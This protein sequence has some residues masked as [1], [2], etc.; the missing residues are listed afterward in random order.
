MK[1]AVLVLAALAGFGAAVPSAAQEAM[2]TVAVTGFRAS[3][4]TTIPFVVLTRRADHLYTS[5]TVED[6]TRDA[7]IRTEELRNTLKAVLAA[8][9]SD[10]SITLSVEKNEVLKDFTEELIDLHITSGSRSDTSQ[11]RILVKTAIN[12]NDTFD[13]ATGRI[14]AFIKRIPKIGRSE[15]T[16][17]SEY[18]IAVVG[19]QQYHAAVIA[20]IA[21][22]AKESATMFGS[23]YGVT[24]E[25]LYR[26]LLWYRA[27][28]L[29]LALYIPY[30][31]NVQPK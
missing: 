27:G 24:I 12:A 2:E 20:K 14:E 17:S 28:Q 18:E 30:T 21:A 13:S 6:D 7:K 1:K 9:K 10:P 31:M 8:A 11:A 25:G 16:S 29:D 26:P 19:P 3:D 15:T 23:D 5:I 22:N 4:S